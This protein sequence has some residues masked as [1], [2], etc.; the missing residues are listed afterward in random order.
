MINTYPLWEPSLE[1]YVVIAQVSSLS[2]SVPD[3]HHVLPVDN[4]LLMMM[5][6]TSPQSMGGGDGWRNQNSD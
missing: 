2:L 5:M 6:D 4:D 3:H 1:V